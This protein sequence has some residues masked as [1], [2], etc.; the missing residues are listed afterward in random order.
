MERFRA[1]IPVCLL[2]ATIGFAPPA[3]G[4]IAAAFPRL[5]QSHAARSG[6]ARKDHRGL[7]Q[8]GRARRLFL[9]VADG[10]RLQSPA[11]LHVDQA[12]RDGRGR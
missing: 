8:T 6:R 11:A 1:S 7:R 2:L 4:A 9:G 3:N 5:D 12:D 10:E